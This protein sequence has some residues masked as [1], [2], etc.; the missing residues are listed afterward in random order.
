MNGLLSMLQN[1][2]VTPEVVTRLSTS[3][4]R[5]WAINVG[6]FPTRYAAE[7]MLLKTALAEMST[8]EGSLRKVVVGKLGFEANFVGLS[9][10]SAD[11]ACRRLEARNVNCSTLDPA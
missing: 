3:G 1:T 7:K 5:D 8:L 6:R 11:R 10:A 9:E 2:P 4:G